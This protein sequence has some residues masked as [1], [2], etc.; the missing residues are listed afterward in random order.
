[1]SKSILARLGYFVGGI[2]LT[3]VVLAFLSDTPDQPKPQAF[4]DSGPALT[5]EHLASK[6]TPIIQTHLQEAKEDIIAASGGPFIRSA[7]RMSFPI[8]VREV[9]PV[10]HHGVSAAL[11]E[12][13]HYSISDFA[14]LLE[15]H[16]A[17]KKTYS[18]DPEAYR[19]LDELKRV[20][21]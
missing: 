13:G 3:L 2:C 6:L 15:A 1:M 17:S 10:V 8:A 7:V 20:Q 19:L 16:L 11:D 5:S 9:D 21:R 4:A 18:A 12:F 14:R